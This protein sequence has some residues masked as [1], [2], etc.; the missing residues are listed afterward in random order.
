MSVGLTTD[1]ILTDLR[2]LCKTDIPKQVEQMIRLCTQSYGKAKLVL[3][4]NRYFIESA[5]DEVLEALLRDPKIGASR[6]ASSILDPFKSLPSSAPP[7]EFKA[8]VP[9]AAAAAAMKLGDDAELDFVQPVVEAAAAEVAEDEEELQSGAMVEQSLR[10]FEINPN[11]VGVVKKRCSELEVPLLEEYDFR[12][13]PRN[14]RL[15]MDLKPSATLR[16]YQRKSLEQMFAT[17]ERDRAWWCWPAG[18]ARR[19]WGFRRRARFKRACWC[20]ARAA[21][22]WTSGATSS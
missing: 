2:K 8:P 18:P 17:G 9:A 15:E 12:N 22:R 11:D 6:I 14:P 21:C 10:S 20:C 1:M 19:W 7:V 16:P 13:D 3:H 4:Q 5:T